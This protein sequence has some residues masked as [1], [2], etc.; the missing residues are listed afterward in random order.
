MKSDG[1]TFMLHL[2][3]SSSILEEDLDNMLSKQKK[4]SFFMLFL[5]FAMMFFV[6]LHIIQILPNNPLILMCFH[7]CYKGNVIWLLII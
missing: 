5:Q 3:P 2:S 4:R 7:F 6:D 1:L